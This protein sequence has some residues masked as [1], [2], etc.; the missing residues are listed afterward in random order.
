MQIT[1]LI[2]S[3]PE[4]LKLD[5]YGQYWLLMHKWKGFRDGEEIAR[6]RWKDKSIYE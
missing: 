5:R 1:V 4:E 3:E 6:W 2:L